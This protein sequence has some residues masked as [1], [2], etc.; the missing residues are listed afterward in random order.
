MKQLFEVCNLPSKNPRSGFPVPGMRGTLFF[1]EF[2][3][4]FGGPGLSRYF[5]CQ[6]TQVTLEYW[7]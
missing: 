5:P 7:A 2:S 4:S 1:P 3:P 6:G